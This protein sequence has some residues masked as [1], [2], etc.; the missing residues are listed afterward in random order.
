[1]PRR[2]WHLTRRGEIDDPAA[3]V[4]LYSAYGGMSG[5]YSR[6]YLDRVARER[7]EAEDRPEPEGE[8]DVHRR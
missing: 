8:P 5:A 3:A 1:M 6:D 4:G 2:K 7:Q